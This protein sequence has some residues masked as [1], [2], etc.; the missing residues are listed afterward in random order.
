MVDVPGRRDLR[1]ASMSSSAFSPAAGVSGPS[2]RTLLLDPAIERR[3]FRVIALIA[4]IVVLSIA[5]LHMT[6]MFLRGVGMSEGNPIARWII[7]HNSG[8]LLIV[9]KLGLVALGCFLFYA[10]RRTR[11]A[12]V[13]CWFCFAMLIWLTMQWASYATEMADVPAGWHLIA[14]VEGYNWVRLND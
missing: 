4:A 2:D 8:E 6:L 14:G 10:A 7:S 11:L 3:A 5:D 12:E 13:G 1:G 9:Y